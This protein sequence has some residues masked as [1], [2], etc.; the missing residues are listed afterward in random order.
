MNTVAVS[1]SDGNE[2]QI[3]GFGSFEN[4]AAVNWVE[5]LEDADD[6]QMV[7][8]TLD[9][10][11]AADE[12]GD[13]PDPDISARA[14]AAAETV[15]ALGEQP[16]KALPEEIRQWCFDN[17]AFDLDEAQPKAMH[18]LGVILHESGLREV[19]EDSG[20]ADD[21]ETEVEE[22]RDRLRAR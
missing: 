4:E 18:A 1:R 13:I 17:P 10:V 8:E 12:R 21:W 3:W 6:L 7:E 15:A 11:L 9:E 5:S 19:V 2:L 22:L 16:A 14:I 20:I